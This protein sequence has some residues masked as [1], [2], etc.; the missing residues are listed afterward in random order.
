VDQVTQVNIGT[1]IDA[2]NVVVN[3]TPIGV[4]G[5]PNAVLFLG[6]APGMVGVYQ[7]NFVLPLGLPPGDAQIT[8]RN[9]SYNSMFGTTNT[10]SS[11]PVLL[12]VR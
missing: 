5:D 6:L 1:V 4:V 3:D 10:S 9:T 11:S 2:Y 12:P 7:A 8:L